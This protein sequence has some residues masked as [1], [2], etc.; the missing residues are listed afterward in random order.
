MAELVFVKLG[1]SLITDKT[2]PMTARPD[3]I[4][5]CAR[6][7]AVAASAGASILV[8]HGSGSFGHSA[9]KRHGT[10]DGVRGQEAWQGFAEVGMIARELDQMVVR[11]L[12]RAGVPAVSLP[13]SASA[14]AR[15]G[16]L[17]WLD[18]WVAQALLAVGSTPVVFG[19]VA[20]D[21]EWG[22]TII[23]TEQVFAYL[24]KRLKP[25]RIVL[26]GE[27][28]GVYDRDPTVFPDATLHG[29]IGPENYHRVLRSVGEARGADVTGG[30]ADKLHRMYELAAQVG[31]LQVQ[32]ISGLEPDLLRR[33]ILGQ[34]VGE[35]TVIIV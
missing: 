3:V 33:A 1:G 26:A 14:R 30:M 24:A 2:Q 34:A 20:V 31:D 9:A 23:S 29:A 5:R 8:G 13:P 19:D 4:E 10:R 28:N 18:S 25:A 6:E 27:V 22:G 11:A 12:V 32:I 35:G 17:T 7:I 15:T 21:E 16:E